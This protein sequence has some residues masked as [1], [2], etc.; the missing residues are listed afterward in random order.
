MQRK[1]AIAESAK[2][3]Y[4]LAVLRAKRKPMQPSPEKIRAELSRI[5]YEKVK[6]RGAK[7]KNAVELKQWLLE[8]RHN[9]EVSM[10]EAI[11][12]AGTYWSVAKHLGLL[13]EK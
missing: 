3:T 6:A 7:N 10:N 5:G 9:P 12:L 2:K 13:E 8:A 11:K 1:R 4:A